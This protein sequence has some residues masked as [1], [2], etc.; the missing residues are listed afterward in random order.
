MSQLKQCVLAVWLFYWCCCCVW[1]A[2]LIYS[3]PWQHV[4][5]RIQICP[6]SPPP[7]QSF[8]LS[9]VD[10][11]TWSTTNFDNFDK[12]LILRYLNVK[13]FQLKPKKRLFPKISS[14]SIFKILMWKYASR[15][16]FSRLQFVAKKLNSFYLG[17]H[18]QTNGLGTKEE[19]WGKTWIKSPYQDSNVLR[20]KF[21]QLTFCDI[22]NLYIRYNSL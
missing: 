20:F 22:N 11:K 10:K 13:C 3:N 7:P 6:L 18:D 19:T 2:N 5:V 21:F 17:W 15:L 8:A 9:R 4:S 16:S 14:F 12:H 1:E